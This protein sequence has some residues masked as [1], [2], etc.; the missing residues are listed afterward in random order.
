MT[1]KSKWNFNEIC[2]FKNPQDNQWY[3]GII[4]N[5]DSGTQTLLVEIS[6]V[7]KEISMWK[8]TKE[9]AIRLLWP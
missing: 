2:E 7:I 6:G 4:T 1:K 8:I 5:I 3:P 9:E